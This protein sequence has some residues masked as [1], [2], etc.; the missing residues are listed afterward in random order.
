MSGAE[1]NAFHALNR[2]LGEQIRPM[3]IVLLTAAG[4]DA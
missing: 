4:F 3:H 1:P 2:L